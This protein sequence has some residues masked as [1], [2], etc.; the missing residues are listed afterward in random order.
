[1]LLGG[2]PAY[3]LWNASGQ[4][5][6]TWQSHFFPSSFFFQPSHYPWIVV[7]NLGVLGTVLFYVSCGYWVGWWTFFKYSIAPYLYVN[8]WL[9]IITYLQHT[10][11]E[12]PYFNHHSFTFLRGAFATMDRDY[13]ILNHFFHHI[14]DSHRI[15]HMFSTM[16]HYHAIQATH[17]LKFPKDTTPIWKALWRTFRHCRSVSEHPHHANV[18]WHA[19]LHDKSD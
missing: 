8:M 4:K 2:W 18:F 5:V 15:H 17:L 1:M 9:I 19:P 10:H 3:L 6:G 11:P 14:G 7:S 13:G 12:V 16:P